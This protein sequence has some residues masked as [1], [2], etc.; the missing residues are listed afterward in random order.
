[1]AQ[2]EIK[3]GVG[4]IPDGTKKIKKY[5]FTGCTSL[6]SITIPES[7]TNIE[8]NAFRGCTSLQSI[9]IPESVTEI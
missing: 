9:T 7:V 6:K 3:D 8:D 2:F 5:A 4:I 1:M